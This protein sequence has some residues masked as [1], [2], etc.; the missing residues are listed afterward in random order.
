MADLSSTFLGIPI[1]NPLVVG[2]S[3]LTATLSGIRKAEENGAGAIVLKSLFEEQILP[4]IRSQEAGLDTYAHPEARDYLEQMGMTLGAMEYLD[5]MAQAASQCQVPLVASI[6]CASPGMWQDFAAKLQAAG[7]RGIELNIGILPVNPAESSQ[8]IEDRVVAVV[9]SVRSA[10]SLPLGVKLGN[11]WTNL[12]NLARRLC[13][14]KIQ[15]LVLFN[16][17]YQLDIN[18][19]TQTLKPGIVFSSPQDYYPA[20]RW[21]ALSYKKL[22]AEL[23]AAG[24]VHES[25]S[26]I[27]LI[28]A[29]ASS[30]QVC[31]ALYKHGYQFLRTLNTDLAQWMDN[32]GHADLAG[33]RG[34]LSSQ[35]S[36][37]PQ[38]YERL[39]YIKAL[40]GVY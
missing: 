28:L 19:E 2:A 5:F 8:E 7:A 25:A 31:S 3:S 35:D 13:E 16:R 23:I 15:G 34:R 21:I 4:G 40:T 38:A 24:G 33:F 9:R 6:N 10:T 27:K 22:P 18:P 36:P 39:Q 1:A 26:L 12:P 30:V 17:F 11:S 14:L 37:D 29:G 32:K 20:L